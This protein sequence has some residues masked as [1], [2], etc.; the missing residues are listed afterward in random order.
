[1]TE[2]EPTGEYFVKIM[3]AILGLIPILIMIL[4]AGIKGFGL[5]I[6][7]TSKDQLYNWKEL[8]RN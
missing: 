5:G 4:W 1:M 3:A 7:E 6:A 8:W 2:K